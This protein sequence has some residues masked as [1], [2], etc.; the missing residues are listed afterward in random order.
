MTR[1]ALWGAIFL[2][3]TACAGPSLDPAPPAGFNLSGEWRLVADRSDTTPDQGFLD[4][5]RQS[6]SHE[7]AR[8]GI[9]TDYPV[10]YASRM[11]IEQNRDSMG[12][13]YDQ[14]EYR[15][16]SWGKRERGMWTV[17]AGWSSGALYIYSRAHDSRGVE[18][19]HLSADGNTLT[20]DVEVHAGE[21]IR[22]QRVFRRG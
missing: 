4:N 22:V 11:K 8:H 18:V 2:L 19:M 6:G 9:G 20:V 7:L 12:I 5:S 13:R 21:K 1:P 15:D 17:D 3:I 14:S 10:V 16:V